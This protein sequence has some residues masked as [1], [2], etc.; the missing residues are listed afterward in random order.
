MLGIS[1]PSL[2]IF[3][4]LKSDLQV[5]Q[6]LLDIT[7]SI[8]ISLSREIFT[9]HGDEKSSSALFAWL[10]DLGYPSRINPLYVAFRRTEVQ[11]NETIKSAIS[12]GTNDPEDTYLLDSFPIQVS[13]SIWSLINSPK[14]MCLTF[15]FCD[16]ILI[17][18]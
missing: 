4:K 9:T 5:E 8:A 3:A 15:K 13:R 18:R 2:Q 16:I 14:L 6:I 11:D 10:I 17:Q 12:S 7:F 1:K